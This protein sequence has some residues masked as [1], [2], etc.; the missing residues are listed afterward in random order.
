MYRVHMFQFGHLIPQDI[1]VNN[2]QDAIKRIKGALS[3]ASNIYIRHE[4]QTE[5]VTIDIVVEYETTI[6]GGEQRHF[7]RHF[8]MVN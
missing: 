7:K 8:T 5:D 3:Y 4:D 1:W 2:R 6:E